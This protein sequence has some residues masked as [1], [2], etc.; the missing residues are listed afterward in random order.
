MVGV[1]AVLCGH[2]VRIAP[3]IR[4]GRGHYTDALTQILAA[5]PPGPIRLGS[6]HDF[7]NLWVI[8]FYM[9][10]LAGGDR[11]QYL[12]RSEWENGAPEWFLT[13]SLSG[14]PAREEFEIDRVGHYRLVAHFPSADHSGW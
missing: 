9:P 10:Y 6:D 13:H 5:A 11:I 7:R 12:P 1:A 2:V 14:V 8:M 4:H 3:L